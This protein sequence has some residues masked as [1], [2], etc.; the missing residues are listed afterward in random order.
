MLAALPAERD[1][2]WFADV[3]VIPLALPIEYYGVDAISMNEEGSLECTEKRVIA[4]RRGVF[5]DLK[6]IP[7]HDGRCRKWLPE[8]LGR[9]C[10]NRLPVFFALA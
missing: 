7:K 3:A 10:R 6:R 2:Q 4:L 1:L 5:A 8:E 9:E